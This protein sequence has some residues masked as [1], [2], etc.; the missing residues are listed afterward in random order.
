MALFINKK[1]H[2]YTNNPHPYLRT[3]DTKKIQHTQS[4]LVLEHNTC[5]VCE[6]SNM[7]IP[8]LV[9]EPNKPPVKPFL[10][11]L[12]LICAN[13]ASQETCNRINQDRIML[14]QIE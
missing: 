4:T 3:L 12:C 2:M 14:V 13:M 6:E 11:E 1:S 9:I 8:T 7:L 5:P 10:D